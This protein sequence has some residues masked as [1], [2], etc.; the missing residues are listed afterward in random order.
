MFKQD[1]AEM[2]H[3]HKC[4]DDM[5]TVRCSLLW[6]VSWHLERRLTSWWPQFIAALLPNCIHSYLCMAGADRTAAL[7]S[8]AWHGLTG[9]LCTVNNDVTEWTGFERGSPVIE[10]SH[11]QIP[12]AQQV[13]RITLNWDVVLCLFLTGLH[14]GALQRRQQQFWR[15]DRWPDGLATGNVFV[16]LFD[17]M[18]FISVASIRVSVSLKCA[19]EHSEC[20]LLLKSFV[21][22][23]LVGSQIVDFLTWIS[24]RPWC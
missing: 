6:F 9:C 2:R 3:S 19:Y 18:F 11:G 10:R 7:S 13:A 4:P 17:C 23:S 8:L 22:W 14:L 15:W 21:F 12:V 5:F 1:A 16:D 20:F 24:R